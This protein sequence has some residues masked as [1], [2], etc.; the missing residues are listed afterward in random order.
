MLKNI[1]YLFC[2]QYIADIKQIESDATLAIILSQG[3]ITWE[4]TRSQLDSYEIPAV[5]ELPV[6]NEQAY[7]FLKK[8]RGS[9][10]YWQDQLYDVLTMLW[11]LSFPTFVPNIVCCWFTLALRWIQAVAVQFG[12]K[13]SQRDVLKMSIAERSRYLHQNLITGVMNVST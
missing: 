4:G 12:K 7:K 13:L 6:R 8:V 10:I 9:P 11:T 3:R 1:E 5:L 2:A